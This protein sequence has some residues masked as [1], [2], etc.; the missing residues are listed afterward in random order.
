[1]KIKSRTSIIVISLF[2]TLIVAV[3]G[4]FS[5]GYIQTLFADKTWIADLG[6]KESEI[7]KLTFNLSGDGICPQIPVKVGN[8]EY[9]LGFDTGC[10][11]GISFTDAIQDKI[12]YT[13]LNKAEATNRDGCHRGW[14]TNVKVNEI[15][16]FGDTYKNVNTSISDW[17]MYSSQKFNGNIGLAYFKSKVITLDYEGHKIAVSSSPIDYAKLDTGKYVVLP[18][19]KTTTK[20]QEDLLFFEAEYNSEPIIVY[21]DTG[22]NHSYLYNPEINYSIGMG[23]NK[24]PTYSNVNLKIADMDLTLNNIVEANNFKQADGLPYPTMIEM[25]SDQI[26]KCNLLVTVDL[27]DQKIIFRRL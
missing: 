9:E 2:L 24:R 10:G 1:M 5:Y 4:Y 23:E 8:D 20:G 15:N 17:S 7:H 12:D 27:I 22:K 25:N 13:V 16:V 3:G 14:I 18:L 26:W 6:Y 19:Y 21:L 11:V